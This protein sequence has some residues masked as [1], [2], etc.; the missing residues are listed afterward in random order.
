VRLVATVL[1][2]AR[3]S[4][5]LAKAKSRTLTLNADSTEAASVQ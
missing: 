2:S 3:G 1:V 5:T 4:W